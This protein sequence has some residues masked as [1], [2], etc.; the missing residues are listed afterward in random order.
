MALPLSPGLT[1]GMVIMPA[2]SNYDSA[3][4]FIRVD[5]NTLYSYATGD[6]VNEAKAVAGAIDSIVNIWNNLQLG[7]AGASAAEAQDFSKRWVQAVQQLFGT[8]DQPDSG[9]FPKLANAVATASVNYGEAEDTV[10]K[11]FQSLTDGLNA[12]PGTPG[13][14]TRG[15][16]QPPITENA[17]PPS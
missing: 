12:P 2:P 17:P 4:L 15:Q 9:A 1:E 14:P 7:W 16:N 5:P 3:G 8:G 10:Q 11:M 6:M 13:P